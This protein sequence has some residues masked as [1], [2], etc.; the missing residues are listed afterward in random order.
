MTD[1]LDRILAIIG[2]N[3]RKNREKTQV[4]KNN[5]ITWLVNSKNILSM[6]ICSTSHLILNLNLINPT[7]NPIPNHDH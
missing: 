6:L 2:T 4:D 1:L 3:I 7:A 5:K